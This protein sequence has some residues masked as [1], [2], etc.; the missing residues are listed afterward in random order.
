VCTGSIDSIVR[1]DEELQ[2]RPIL[3]SNLTFLCAG[4]DSDAYFEIGMF[5]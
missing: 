1:V 3:E 5:R 2:D 4:T